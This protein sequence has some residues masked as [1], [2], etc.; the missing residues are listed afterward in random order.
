[1]VVEVILNEGGSY[2]SCGGCELVMDD[3]MAGS[4][5]EPARTQ[6]K[7]AASSSSGKSGC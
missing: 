4:S 7:M 5:L 2:K 1:M 6:T 3:D